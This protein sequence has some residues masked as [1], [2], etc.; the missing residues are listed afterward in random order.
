[1][2]DADFFQLPFELAEFAENP[3]PRCPVLLLLDNSYSM[4][5]AKIDALNRALVDFKD[6]LSSDPLAAARCEVAIVSFG[7]V[8]VVQEF[9]AAHN[10]IPPHLEAEQNTPLGEAVIRGLELLKNRKETIRQGGVG[11]YRP[12]VFLITDGAPTDDWHQA[13]AEIKRGEASKAFAFFSVGVDDADM[14]MLSQLSERAPLK[15]QGLK[16]RELFQW[17]SASLKSVSQST[18]GDRVALSNPAG[19]AEV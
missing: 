5:G 6:E 17:L 19:W 12:W 3:E 9:T 11:L 2:T 10:F 15:L 13:A 14:H 16:F 18:P 7:P 1:M 4:S 8:R